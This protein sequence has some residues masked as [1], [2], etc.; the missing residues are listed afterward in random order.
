MELSRDEKIMLS[1]LRR[2][3]KYAQ[4]NRQ[5]ALEICVLPGGRVL[6]TKFTFQEKVE[7]DVPI[8]SQN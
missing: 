3:K 5:A 6:I 4:D 7:I 2:A 1:K 8:A